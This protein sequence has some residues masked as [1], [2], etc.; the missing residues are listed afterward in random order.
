MSLTGSELVESG[1]IRVKGV[2]AYTR[3]CVCFRGFFPMRV[4]EGGS[5]SLSQHQISI[6]WV[7]ACEGRRHSLI[8]S[9]AKD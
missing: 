5:L 1:R 3:T 9:V 4:S 8:C 2:C 6:S 7:L